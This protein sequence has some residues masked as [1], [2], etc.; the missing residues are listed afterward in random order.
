MTRRDALNFML[1]SVAA[2]VLYMGVATIG[3]YLESKVWPAYSRFTIES[4]EPYG[5]NQSRVVFS[6]WKYRMCEPQGFAWFA[7]D[8]GLSYRQLTMRSDA[9]RATPPRPLGYNLSQPYIV[10]VEPNALRDGTFAE[11]YSR[12]HPFWVSRSSIYP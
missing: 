8:L 6:Y 2:M 10:D 3:P 5:E 4:I 9:T 12:C 1:S 11:I 7:G